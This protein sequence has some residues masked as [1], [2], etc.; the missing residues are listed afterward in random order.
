M[1]LASKAHG[2]RGDDDG[3]VGVETWNSEKQ[4][5]NNGLFSPLGH[6]TSTLSKWEA[7]A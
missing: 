5:L 4:V 7:R 2:W 6:R 1:K 3:F